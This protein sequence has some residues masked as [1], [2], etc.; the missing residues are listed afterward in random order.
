M[1]SFYTNFSVSS[2]PTSWTTL[3]SFCSLKVHLNYFSL[4]SVVWAPSH[5]RLFSIGADFNCVWR[6]YHGI[7]SVIEVQFFLLPYCW[8]LPTRG[9]EAGRAAPQPCFCEQCFSLGL[10][11]T[12]KEF[13]FSPDDMMGHSWSSALAPGPSVWSLT[14]FLV[15][16][17]D[18]FSLMFCCELDTTG[19]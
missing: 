5:S 10:F 7:S 16:D 3:N 15:T 17:W 9:S 8:S 1:W 12:Q 2:L 13:P 14:E 11:P 4:E 6:Q 19:V 18:G